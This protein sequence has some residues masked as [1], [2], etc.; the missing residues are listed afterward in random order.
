[1]GKYALIIVSALVFSILTYSSGLRNAMFSSTLRMVDTFTENQ[2]N[3]IAQSTMM[4]VMNDISEKGENSEFVPS[5]GGTY[6]SSVDSFTEWSDVMGSY[7]IESVS[8]GDTLRI[9][10]TGLYEEN[11]SRSRAGLVSTIPIWNPQFP[12][13]VHTEGDLILNGSAHIKGNASTNSTA[14]GAVY[15]S[16][17]VKI[18]STL[19][20]GPGGDPNTVVS[21]QDEFAENVG[22]ETEAMSE[23][24]D[25]Q[26]PEFPAYPSKDL[27]GVSVNL[28]G[29]TPRTLSFSEY[30][31]Y[32][33]PEVTVQS[34]NTLTIELDGESVL[35]T[36]KFTIQGNVKVIGTG[37]LKLIVEDTF[38]I[39]GGS[40][41]N[42][43]ADTN[44]FFTY[45]GGTT[46]LSFGGTT[47]Y[48]AG[49][50][51]KTADIT[52]TGTNT[53]QGSLISG[54]TNVS[55]SGNASV[56]SRIIYAPFADVIMS[57][58]SVIYGSVVSNSFT[59]SNSSIVEL[60]PISEEDLPDLPLSGG[61]VY[62]L[63]YWD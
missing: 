28:S 36:S 38:S 16:S 60:T 7:H 6:R 17:S 35:Y 2:A 26:M 8:S 34:G 63:L 19:Y 27:V 51:L 57:G 18:D 22:L 44:L 25:Y 40:T 20:V 46:S 24:Q 58:S 50:F 54:G 12:S 53:F 3:S 62:T 4:I 37:S 43:G 1:M 10:T 59:A 11:E 32:Y 29:N 31:G 15:L 39:A 30:H 33:L 9:V 45:Y 61:P 56:N 55:L 23:E 5:D 47:I 14:A 21:L 49:L 13:A 48:N 42:D 52:V 41:I